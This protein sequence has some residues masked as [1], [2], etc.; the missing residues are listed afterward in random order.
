M[1]SYNS[2]I[3]QKLFASLTVGESRSHKAQRSKPSVRF[4]SDVHHAPEKP[5]R[6][7]HVRDSQSSRQS[8]GL[9]GSSRHNRYRNKMDLLDKALSDSESELEIEVEFTVEF[10]SPFSILFTDE[11]CKKKWE[12]FIEIT[13]E[14][15][16]E[17]LSV[18]YPESS[19]YRR[20][21]RPDFP[22]APQ[23][24]FSVLNRDEKRLLKKNAGNPIIIQFE[25]VIID[26]I[27]SRRPTASVKLTN[28]ECLLFSLVSIYYS[29]QVSAEGLVGE[30]A[31][32]TIR[33]PKGIQLPSVRLSEYLLTFGDV[34]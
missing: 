11:E 13:E 18:F 24:C 19:K 32:V 5:P 28:Y 3:E 8:I 4:H 31:M 2:D 17:L 1:L 22:T 7:K 25:N 14:E 10:R 26:L 33:K 29:L 30:E 12:P 16:N 23:D 6:R 9:P 27:L 15:Q 21:K 34:Q 20:P